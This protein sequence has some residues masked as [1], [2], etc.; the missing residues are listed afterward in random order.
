[1]ESYDVNVPIETLF[2]RIEECFQYAAAGNTPFTVAQ[3][4]S[5]SFRVIQKT[6]MFTDDCKIW[7]RRPAV[8]K[9]W[10]QLKLDFAMAHAELRESQQTSKLA[11]FQANNAEVIPKET[12]EAIA[13][14]AS[15]TLADR[16]TM[17]AMQ[18]TISTLTV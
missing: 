12:A 1:M 17:T 2:R 6:G 16:N 18:L 15:A 7:N 10:A 9:I 13:N 4:V 14:L 5:T 3:V 8:E 11:G